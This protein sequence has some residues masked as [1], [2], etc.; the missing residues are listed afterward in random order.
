M[1]GSIFS[2]APLF[3]GIREKEEGLRREAIKKAHSNGEEE[4]EGGG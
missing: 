2:Q 4:L 1:S 3:Q